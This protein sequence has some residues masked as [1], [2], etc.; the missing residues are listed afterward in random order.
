MTPFDLLILALFTWRAAYFIAKENGPFNL[1]G[2]FRS[3]YPLGGLTTCLYCASVWTAA[4][5]FVLGHTPLQP[6]VVIGAVSGAA[7]MLASYSGANH[8]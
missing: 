2:R 4:L 8:A 1:M 6:L 3:R 7:L 5:G